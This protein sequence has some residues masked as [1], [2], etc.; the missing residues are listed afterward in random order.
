MIQSDKL[1]LSRFRKA[2]PQL[3]EVEDEYI[4][5]FLGLSKKTKKWIDDSIKRKLKS[6]RQE[7]IF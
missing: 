1:R 7:V 6:L 4:L 5:K 3:D 2:Y